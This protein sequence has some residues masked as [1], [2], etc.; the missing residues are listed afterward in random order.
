MCK[1]GINGVDKKINGFDM[2]GLD[3]IK[4]KYG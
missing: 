1:R 3:E 4:L 2:D